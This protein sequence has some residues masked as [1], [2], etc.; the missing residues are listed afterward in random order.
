MT[1]ILRFPAVVY[2]ALVLA[3]ALAAQAQPRIDAALNGASLQE[4]PLSPGQIVVLRGEGLGP[5][6]AVVA[7]ADAQGSLPTAL[8]GVQ[9]IIGGQAS[10]L[11]S[12]QAEEVRTQAPY[13]LQ[14]G[15]SVEILVVF[16]GEESDPVAAEVVTTTPEIF[17][18]SSGR[19]M[20][21]SLRPDGILVLPGRP[22]EP[23]EAIV[24]FATGAGD[25]VPPS[26]TGVVASPPYPTPAERVVLRIGGVAAVLEY[27]GSAPGYAGMLQ[28]NAVVPESVAAA[29]AEILDGIS[30]E[31]LVPVELSVGAARSETVFL[32]VDMPGVNNPP[33]AVDDEAETEENKFVL[34]SVLDNDSDVDGEDL[35]LGEIGKA[36]HGEVSREGSAVRYTPSRGFTGLDSFRYVAADPNEGRAEAS[37][38]VTVRPRPD[39]ENEDPKARGV[40]TSVVT[41]RSKRI[42]LRARDADGDVLEFYIVEPPLQGELGPLK[43]VNANL[44]EVVYQ[45]HE[46]SEGADGFLFGVE[47]G[48]GG[49]GQARVSIEI[50]PPPAEPELTQGNPD[51]AVTPEDTPVLVDVL[52]NDE[53]GDNAGVLTVLNVSSTEHGEATIGPGGVTFTP[54]ENFHGTG[55]F[56]Y[57]IGE[58]TGF[59][60]PVPV[61]VEVTPVDDPPLFVSIDP[62]FEGPVVSG[63]TESF[64]IIVDDPD[65]DLS[66]LVVTATSSNQTVLPNANIQVYDGCDDDHHIVEIALPSEADGQTIVTLTVSDGH[67]SVHQTASVTVESP[68][69]INP[70]INGLAATW[71]M[72]VGSFAFPPFSVSY[73]GTGTLSGSVTS[74]N[75]SVIPD[76]SLFT[77]VLFGENWE[78]DIFGP[79]AAGVAVLTLTITDG[80][81]GSD[82]EQITVTVTG[83]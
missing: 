75:Q 32:A 7:T 51:A 3:S 58:D 22:A 41:G 52:A 17:R 37:V 68:A 82:Q 28:L 48:A 49:E 72:T 64:S 46:G 40:D 67:S 2:A 42:P 59:V 77:H 16:E 69:V 80:L 33:L 50:L 55:G 71:D 73:G 43:R 44:A 24:F 9:V 31:N 57:T 25:T 78:I 61:I 66:Q 36:V 54:E 56:S 70:V 8:G 6:E 65:T 79:P 39:G 60:G 20:A 27:A 38:F 62:S 26:R 83:P 30:D 23:G 14:S 4:G 18:E 45:S 47:D 15:S 29:T 53:P 1:S 63:N 35:T 74:D 11:F 13:E 10:P 34:I 12:V 76:G 19:P 5:D 21:A 81:G